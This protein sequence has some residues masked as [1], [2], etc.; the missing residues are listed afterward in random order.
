MKALFGI[1]FL[2]ACSISSFAQKQIIVQNPSAHA[3]KELI[4]IPFEKFKTSFSVDTVFSIWDEQGNEL[5]HQLEKLGQS[6]PQNVLILVDLKAKEKVKLTVSGTSGKVYPARTYARYVP[7]RYDD[8]AW[9]NDVVAFRM[10]GKALEGRPD[11]AQGM[12]YWAKRTDKLIIDAWYKSGDYHKD[13]GEGLDY[14]SVGQTLGM[15]DMAFYP[16]GKIHYSKHYR[17]FKL[18]DNGPLR[19]TFV[20]IYEPEI[21]QGQQIKLQ[22]KIS[23]DAGS[24]F[25]RIELSMHNA[26]TITTPFVI[27]L[28]KRKEKEPLFHLGKGNRSLSYWEPEINK[29]GRTGVAIIIPSG[30]VEF[31][32]DKP[33]QFLLLSEAKNNRPF[34]YYNGAT[35]NRAGKI[36]DEKAWAKAVEFEKEKIE[37]PLKVTIK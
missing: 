3:R 16:E 8:F 12:D 1:L 35:W 18:L 25:N 24:H 15:G 2:L 27:G 9:E 20:L 13:H 29:S 37:K 34:V 36:T 33:E 19:S 10:Y 6:S 21:N 11:D 14:Y 4:A 26:S 22:K 7:E 23:L 32:N 28:A 5:P 31:I 30:K 17:S